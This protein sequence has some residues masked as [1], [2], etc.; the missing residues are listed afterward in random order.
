[1]CRPWQSG[2]PMPPFH[3]TTCDSPRAR[4]LGPL[5]LCP[6]VPRTLPRGWD[7]RRPDE[8][9]RAVGF[10][11]TRPATAAARVLQC[12]DFQPEL[13][14]P[15]AAAEPDGMGS[16]HPGNSTGSPVRARRGAGP[17]AG[18]VVCSHARM[19]TALKQYRNCLETAAPG[20]L[21]V[22]QAFRLLT[23]CTQEMSA[24]VLMSVCPL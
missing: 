17:S 5:D 4:G 15:S 8:G 6:R 3:R 22:P 20:R 10:L 19:H 1:M 16:G 23:L 21:R 9:G 7:Q 14:C 18:L 24:F 13:S 2:A 11:G 12:Q